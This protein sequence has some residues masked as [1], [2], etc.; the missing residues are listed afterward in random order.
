MAKVTVR[1]G[2]T[3]QKEGIEQAKTG[4]QSLGQQ[5]KA[6]T[7]QMLAGFAALSIGVAAVAK[8]LNTVKKAIQENVTLYA[9]QEKV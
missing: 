6:S 2:S 9:E 3:F 4:V 5:T 1:V 7:A 8:V